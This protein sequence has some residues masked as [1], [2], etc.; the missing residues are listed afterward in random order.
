MGSIFTVY[1]DAGSQV[2]A[3]FNA[4]SHHNVSAGG[5]WTYSGSLCQSVEVNFIQAIY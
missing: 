3:Q 1:N 2:T 4:G 5:E